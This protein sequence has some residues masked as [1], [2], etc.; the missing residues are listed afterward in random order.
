VHPASRI[1]IFLLVV[2]HVHPIHPLLLIPLLAE[3][4]VTS[5]HAAGAR[6]GAGLPAVPAFKQGDVFQGGATLEA[7][8]ILFALVTVVVH[9]PILGFR[10]L[11]LGLFLLYLL[12]LNHLNR[13]DLLI[14]SYQLLLSQLGPRLSFFKL[15]LLPLIFCLKCLEYGPQLLDIEL[16][17]PHR[18]DQVLG[19]RV[20]GHMGVQ[21]VMHIE[22]G[23]G[24]GLLDGGVLEHFI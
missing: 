19:L 5:L 8:V 7:V 20:K 6:V 21:G 4:K 10:L 2:I 18:E 3:S 11:K 9:G 15:P 1:L 22:V 23:G 16:C 24:V 17:L 14:Y 13:P 12:I